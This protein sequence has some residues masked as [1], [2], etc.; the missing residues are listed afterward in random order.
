MQSTSEKLIENF[1]HLFPHVEL[2]NSSDVFPNY[3]FNSW[4]QKAIIIHK[5][6]GG[7]HVGG[8]ASEKYSLVK[9]EDL[10]LPIADKLDSLFGAKNIDIRLSYSKDFEYHLFFEMKGLKTNVIDSLYPMS[11]ATNSYTTQIQAAQRNL[12]GRLIC[13]NGMMTIS[14]KALLFNVK[15]TKSET[16][17]FMD[18]DTLLKDTELLFNDFGVM[19]QHVDLL[20]SVKLSALKGKNNTERFESIIKGTNFPKKQVESALNIAMREASQLKQNLTLWLAYNGFNHI[21]NHDKTTKM[22]QNMKNVLDTKLINRVHKMA[23]ELA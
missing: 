4:E 17:V 21:L 9:N 3:E 12:I 16:G 13:T 2:V 14:E 6:E 20:N 8:L 19:T 5:P 11:E 23:L 15:H 1:P 10:F 7:F 18:M 22:T